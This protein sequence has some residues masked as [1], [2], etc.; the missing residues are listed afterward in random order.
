MLGN[1]LRSRVR[2][3]ALAWLLTHPDERFFVRQLET[4]L[5]EA[6]G[7]LGKRQ[8]AINSLVKPITESLKRYEE[9]IRVLE[10]ARQKAYGSLEEQV[11]MLTTTNQQLQQ[12]M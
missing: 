11:K 4:I 1:L 5:A 9:H 10:Q 2:A 8:E 6:K 7:D 12:G 3:K